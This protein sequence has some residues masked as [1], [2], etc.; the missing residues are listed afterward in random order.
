MKS[1]NIIVSDAV[2]EKIQRLK[3]KWKA[4]NLNDLISVLVLNQ[5]EEGN[6]ENGKYNH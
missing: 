3:K 5:K 1:M 2:Y 6:T 4:S